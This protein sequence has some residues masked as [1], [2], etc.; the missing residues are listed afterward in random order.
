LTQG[1]IHDRLHRRPHAQCI[2]QHDRRFEV[3]QLL[4]LEET[5]RLAERVGRKDRRRH[6]PL[7]D[8]AVVRHDR[9]DTGAD[10]LPLD[11]GAMTYPDAFDI[12]DRIERPRL[13]NPG[14][15]AEVAHPR[16]IDLLSET[17]E[18]ADQAD[19]SEYSRQHSNSLVILF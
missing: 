13:E 17:W 15:D 8:I 18:A 3:A 19:H 6:L 1:P 10:P 5:R 2:G 11:Q 9:G 7:K 16:T 12:G 14:L 4:H